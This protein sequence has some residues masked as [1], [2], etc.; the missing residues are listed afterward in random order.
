MDK[1]LNNKDSIDLLKFYGLKLP[2]KYKDSSLGEL[3]KAF[4]KGMEETANL[5]KSIK[6]VAEYRKDVISG[7]ILALIF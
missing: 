6:N 4:E 2:S 3:Q 7:L 5:K 1:V